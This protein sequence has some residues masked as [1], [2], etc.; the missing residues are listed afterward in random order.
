MRRTVKLLAVLAVVVAAAGLGTWAQSGTPNIPN[1]REGQSYLRADI[2]KNVV[3]EVTPLPQVQDQGRAQASSAPAERS[4]T[5]HP[6]SSKTG[7]TELSSINGPGLPGSN[8]G[9]AFFTPSEKTSIEIKKVI[10]R[11]G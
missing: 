7:M 10:K 8:F 5:A 11:L 2:W 1:V 6:T 3:A 9:S 4:A